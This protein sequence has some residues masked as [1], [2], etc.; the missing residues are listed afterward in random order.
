MHTSFFMSSHLAARVALPRRLLLCGSVVALTQRRAGPSQAAQAASPA[1]LQDLFL[2]ASQLAN[3]G[4]LEEADETWTK[5][6]EAA[7]NNSASWSNRGAVRLQRLM[8]KEAA[9]DLRHA[10]EDLDK[11]D[12]PGRALALNNYGNALV[13]VH[14]EGAIE[15][16]R[17]AAQ[18]APDDLGEIAGQN[19]ALALFEFGKVQE[20]VD[21]A[22]KLLRRDPRFYDARCALSAFLYAAGSAGDAEREWEALQNDGVGATLYPRKDAGAVA[23]VRNRWPPRATAALDA[24]LRLDTSG[25]AMDWDGEVKSFAITVV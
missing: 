5:A 4:K 2:K 3:E 11:G 14:D 12:S 9:E 10:A 22:R 23:R 15:L 20:A 1:Q 19:V 25:N 7:P 24:F 6:I 13:A 8:W 18:M 17:R 21:E 16:Y